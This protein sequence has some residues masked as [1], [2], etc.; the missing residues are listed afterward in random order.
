MGGIS[1]VMGAMVDVD[2]STLIRSRVI[3]DDYE[4][5]LRKRALV[6][7]LDQV[8]KNYFDGVDKGVH[9]GTDLDKCMSKFDEDKLKLRRAFSLEEIKEEGD[10]WV[11][12]GDEKITLSDESDQDEYMSDAGNEGKNRRRHSF[13]LSPRSRK[14][15]PDPNF[16]AQIVEI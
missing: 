8:G 6:Q 10:S 2:E 5:Q 14:E 15:V 3:D 9:L 7:I 12:S 11:A 16:R 4:I 13:P 1:N